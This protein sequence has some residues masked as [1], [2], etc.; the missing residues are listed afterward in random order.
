[1]FEAG[2]SIIHIINNQL[3]EIYPILK[4]REPGLSDKIITHFKT[5]LE[6]K[7]FTLAD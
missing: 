1:M 7:G 3:Q 5:L 2:F 4:T 6:L